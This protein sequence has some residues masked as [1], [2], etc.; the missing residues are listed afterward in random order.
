MYV[1]NIFLASQTDDIFV[2]PFFITEFKR[3]KKT[4]KHYALL[5]RKFQI[6]SLRWIKYLPS[7]KNT[8]QLER[9]SAMKDRFE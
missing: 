1:A 2:E 7:I 9:V 4:N 8:P 5:G 6:L 3:L